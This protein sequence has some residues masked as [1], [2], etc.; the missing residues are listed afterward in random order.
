MNRKYKYMCGHKFKYKYEYEYKY[1][2][3]CI[4]ENKYNHQIELKCHQI[5][6]VFE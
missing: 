2:Y 5:L 3:K 6:Q 1:E 4:Y